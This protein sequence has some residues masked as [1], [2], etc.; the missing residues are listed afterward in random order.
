MTLSRMICNRKAPSRMPIRRVILNRLYA[1]DYC[2]SAECHSTRCRGTKK[3]S[4]HHSGWLLLWYS[5][6]TSYEI[7][8]IILK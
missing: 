1:I 5:L 3:A 7:L 8:K 4:I 6:K 2:C